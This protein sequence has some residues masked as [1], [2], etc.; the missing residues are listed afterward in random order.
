MIPTVIAPRFGDAVID[1]GLQPHQTPVHSL[2]VDYPFKIELRLHGD[3]ARARVA[4]P[5]HPVGIAHTMTDGISALTVTLCRSASLDRDFVLVIDQLAHESVAVLGRDRVE[6][7][8]IVAMASFCPRVPVQGTVVTAVK[9]LVDCSGSMGGDSID[10]AKRALQA[11]VSQF[12]KG[13]KFSLSR[14][15]S[16][17]EHRS[18]GLWSVTATTRLAALRWVGSLVA[19]LGG[20]EMESALESTFALAHA[21]AS[22]VLLITDGEISAIDGTIESAQAS[23][24]RVFVVGIGSSPAEAHLRR[25]A[26]ATGGACDFVAAGETVEPAIVRMFARLRSPRLNDVTVAWPEG[27]NPEWATS[28][29]NSVFDGDTV[30][31]FA[32]ARFIP[33]GAVGLMAR[34]DDGTE[35]VEIGRAQFNATVQQDDTL[36][37]MAVAERLQCKKPISLVGAQA[38][39]RN[40]AVAYQLVTEQ[41]NF[42]LVH[43]RAEEV[44]PQD[45][46]ELHKVSQM[47]AAGWG[48][49]G[50]V[51]V[52]ETGVQNQDSGYS[53]VRFRMAAS[54]TDRDIPRFSRQSVSTPSVWRTSTRKVANEEVTFAPLS[55]SA[56]LRTTPEIDWPTDYQALAYLGVDR[57]VVEWLE[58]VMGENPRQALTEQIIVRTF[59]FVMA[60]TQIFDKLCSSRP[61]GRSGKGML[62]KVKAMFVKVHGNSG[63]GIDLQLAERMTAALNDMTADDWPDQVFELAV[64]LNTG[65]QHASS[66]GFAQSTCSGEDVDG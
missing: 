8:G 59:L 22:D 54:S 9:I 32:M 28:V 7:D 48:G 50:S 49:V 56:W 40:L 55:L 29:P 62:Q 47:L 53:S 4:C 26:E 33:N 15:G 24:H 3:L 18:R 34:I 31:L 39:T 2:T 6:E 36:S 66:K 57:W 11:I 17:V 58:I 20:T 13:D 44:T 10:A 12:G 61:M 1:G 14:F 52:Q 27:F 5:T 37:R 21:A 64:A 35:L 38:F 43:E 19:D 41:T 46:P 60:S 42:L 45:M 30:N 16:T 63:I 25:L 51:R 65:A 23:G